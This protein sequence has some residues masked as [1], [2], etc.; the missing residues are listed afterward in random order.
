VN[1][2]PQVQWRLLDVQ[3]HDT[4][5][6]QLAHKRRT[7]PQHAAIE[8]LTDRLAEFDVAAVTARTNT[9]DVSRELAKAEADVE[10]VRQRAARNQARLDAGQGT[11]KDMQALQGEL[12]GLGQRQS[13]LEDAEL[14]VMER[15][16]AAEA[17]VGELAREQE[18]VRTRLATVTSDRD[19]Q[20]ADLDGQAEAEIRARADAAAGVPAE[21][22]ALYLKIRDAHGGV[23]AARLYQRR[24]EGCRLELTP[25]DIAHFRAAAE[26]AVLRCE[27]C[28]RIVVRTPDSGL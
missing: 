11:A 9:G 20:L 27:E 21:L 28:S 1:A 24:C 16:E 4:R 12:A 14:E 26:D 19:A 8:A 6:A 25:Q 17:R 3:D 2:A 7:L 18:D 23:G 10:Q 5:L 22:L 13:V 15:L